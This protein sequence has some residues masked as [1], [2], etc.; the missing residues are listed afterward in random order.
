M[1]VAWTNEPSC[2]L[3]MG[4]SWEFP[5]QFPLGQ[6]CA[7]LSPSLFPCQLFLAQGCADLK[8]WKG[9]RGWGPVL[10]PVFF[11]TALPEGTGGG[12]QGSG[13]WPPQLLG[14]RKDLQLFKL[15]VSKVLPCFSP[16]F[17][18]PCRI[19]VSS[20]SPFPRI[21]HSLSDCEH[22]P[23]FPELS[24]LNIQVNYGGFCRPPLHRGNLEFLNLTLISCSRYHY[25]IGFLNIS[26]LL[27]HPNLFIFQ[28]MDGPPRY[29]NYSKIIN[30]WY[31]PKAK[32]AMSVPILSPLSFWEEF[33]RIS[34]HS[35]SVATR[36]VL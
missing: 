17:M 1:W 35:S 30:L 5:K 7:A 18:H 8:A 22:Y 20:N 12:S 13:A 28:M 31:P 25:T 21:L 10:E 11:L 32:G 2:P 29:Q 24:P 33:I 4:V 19:S 23:L 27:D 3:F 26:R 34:V 36:E 15:L 16:L 9:G 14:A 6:E